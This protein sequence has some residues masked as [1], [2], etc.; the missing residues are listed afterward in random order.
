MESLFPYLLERMVLGEVGKDA[1]GKRQGSAREESKGQEGREKVAPAY[2][3][4]RLLRRV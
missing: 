3:S 1:A 2:F 4:E